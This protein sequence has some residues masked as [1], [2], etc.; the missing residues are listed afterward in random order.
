MRILLNYDE[1]LSN[2]KGMIASLLKMKGLTAYSTGKTL[3][4]SELL[5]S[6]KKIQADGILLANEQTLQNCVNSESGKKVSLDKY[7]GSRLDFSIPVIVGAPIN[8]LRIVRHGRWLYEKDLDKFKSIKKPIVQLQFTGLTNRILLD[9][10]LT[11]A[12]QA[13]IISTDIETDSSNRITCVGYSCLNP[14]LTTSTFL[15]PFVDFGVNHWTNP[16]DYAYAINTMRAISAL[17]VAKLYFNGLYDAQYQI[18]YHAEPCNF[19]LDSMALAHAEYSELPKSLDFV[20]SLHLHDYYYWKDDTDEA[21]KKGDIQAYWAYC[22]R[23]SWNTLRCFISQIKNAKP[24]AIRNYKELFKMVYPSIYCAFEG[25]ALDEA[26]LAKNTAKAEEIVESSKRSLCTMAHSPTFNPGSPKQ[27]GLLLFDI[28]G[29]RPVAKPRKKKDGTWTSNRSTDETALAKIAEQHPLFSL[30][31]ARLFEYREQAKAIG[32]YFKFNQWRGIDG[33][34]KQPRLLYGINPFGTDTGR[35]ASN[36]SSFRLFDVI[37]EE[38]R[39]YGTQIQNIPGYAKGM[40]VADSGY[41][42]S[43]ADNNKSE[44]RCVGFLSGCIALILAIEERTKDFYKVLGML[45][46]G[47]KYEDVTDSLRNN[48]LKR[49][50]HGRNYLMG[51]DTFIETVIKQTH[52]TKILYEGARLINYPVRSLKEFVGYLLSLYNKPFPEIETWYK[53]IKLEVVR[54]HTLTSPLGWTRY[55]FGDIIKDHKVFRNAVAHA[56]QNLSVMILNKGL[57]RVYIELVL[58]QNGLFRLKAQIH[59]SIFWQSPVELRHQY[60]ARVLE[61]MNNPVMVKGRKMEIP[62]D[63]KHGQNWLELKK[64]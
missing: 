23:D 29:A 19:I 27:V 43:E 54:N 3:S 26:A 48:I 7:R 60:D 44:A 63:I 50:V 25:C 8:H 5:A 35:A 38:V 45:F 57:W 56:P 30:F 42:L 2:Y 40:L 28:F 13:L 12:E 10:A 22:A 1:H 47:L 52:S 49:I 51:I 33:T 20:A 61:C 11:I 21:R 41:E 34:L 9:K 58:T 14:N 39:S 32:T 36:A 64:S 37:R 4:I 24:Y 55:F 15:I 18:T 62:V 17:P 16:E 31:I 6:A 53:E 59:D 46:F